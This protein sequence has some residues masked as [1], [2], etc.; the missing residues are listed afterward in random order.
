MISMVS[1]DAFRGFTFAAFSAKNI[2]VV[3][4]VVLSPSLIESS[5]FFFSFMYRAFSPS[6]LNHITSFSCFNR[7]LLFFVDLFFICSLK[8]FLVIC[9]KYTSTNRK[10]SN[11]T[12]TVDVSIT[13]SCG[14]VIR[15]K[16]GRRCR[17]ICRGRGRK[18]IIPEYIFF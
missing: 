5:M 18:L 7:L 10:N 13:R 3:V 11:Y 12:N 15:R 8:G 9:K 14:K 17:V 16:R 4:A 6:Y 1:R 2:P